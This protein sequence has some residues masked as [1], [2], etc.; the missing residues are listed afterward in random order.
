MRRKGEG[1]STQE[2]ISRLK[3]ALKCWKESGGSKKST[4]VLTE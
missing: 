3:I 4:H 2:N 1:R